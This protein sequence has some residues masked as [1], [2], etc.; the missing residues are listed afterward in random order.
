MTIAFYKVNGFGTSIHAPVVISSLP[1]GDGNFWISVLIQT[2]FCQVSREH[3]W[4][5]PSV[6][7]FFFFL[8]GGGRGGESTWL[9]TLPVDWFIFLASLRVISEGFFMQTK[10]TCNQS[11]FSVKYFRVFRS[12]DDICVE[13]YV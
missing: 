2:L 4:T 10:Q 5:T 1:H 12:N 3:F 8:G 7:V 13:K 11:I 6:S 9:N